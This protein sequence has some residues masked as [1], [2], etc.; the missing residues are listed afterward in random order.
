MS[1]PVIDISVFGDESIDNTDGFRLSHAQHEIARQVRDACIQV[2]FFYVEGHGC[3]AEVFD[4]M[5]SQ[6]KLFFDQPSDAKNAL[7]ASNNPLWRGYNS[8]E[9]GAHSCTPE[10]APNH[11]PDLK[12]SF[13]IGAESD[14]EKTSSPMHGSNQW[15]MNMNGFERAARTYW[16]TLEQ[17]VAKRLTRALAASLQ[18]PLEFFEKKTTH[19]HSQ[20]V[21][22]RYPPASDGCGSSRSE[23]RRGCGAHTD[24][25]FVTILAQDGDGLEVRKSDGTWALAPTKRETF[26]V[27]LGDMMAHWTNDL[28]KSTEHRVS[29]KGAETRHSIP[30][31]HTVDYDTLVETIPS[32]R[33]FRNG[34]VY[35][36]C[37]SGEYILKKLGLMY[38]AKSK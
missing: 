37:T 12:E 36:C 33:H 22:L 21:L 17:V 15:P 31:F 14:P 11:L 3:P 23:P 30:F 18:L 9:T 1:I 6:M 35:D 34:E 5:F 13:T 24:C 32:C 4:D 26:I 7:V 38:L 29:N 10:D 25:G 20:M 16:N 2:G 19:P 27:N 8:V 28:Y